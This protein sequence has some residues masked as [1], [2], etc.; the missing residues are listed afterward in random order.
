MT[1]ANQ[2][3]NVT[4]APGGPLFVKQL[5]R[6]HRRGGVQGAARLAVVVRLRHRRRGVHPGRRHRRGGH[7]PRR[8]RRAHRR[9]VPELHHPADR[10]RPCRRWGPPRGHRPPWSTS[11]SG[12]RSR[13]CRSPAAR[14]R[15]SESPVGGV[16]GHRPG[17]RSVQ[18]ARR[19]G[20]AAPGERQHR[21]RPGHRVPAG[22][23]HRA[24]GP[25]VAAEHASRRCRR[26]ASSPPI[27]RPPPRPSTRRSRPCSTA[28]PR[29]SSGCSRS[30]TAASWPA[31]SS[32]STPVPSR[33]WRRRATST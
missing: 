19:G 24:G 31:P 5:A 7:D 12:P 13:R 27:P 10:A 23:R 28:P 9:A 30:R 22:R 25:G 2:V 20:L 11:R 15:C 18:R 21:H 29:P 32:S 3:G 14:G 4:V 26:P 1:P 17:R 16:R 6:R 33:P 8:R